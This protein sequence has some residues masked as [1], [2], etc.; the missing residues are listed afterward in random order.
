VQT[1][2]HTSGGA[3]KEVIDR[4]LQEIDDIANHKTFEAELDGLKNRETPL[5][6]KIYQS[7]QANQNDFTREVFTELKNLVALLNQAFGTKKTDTE[8]KLKAFKED[9][10]PHKVKALAIARKFK[11][12]DS[13]PENCV[14]TALEKLKTPQENKLEQARNR[15]K[16]LMKNLKTGGQDAYP[17]VVKDIN[18][19]EDNLTRTAQLFEKLKEISETSQDNDGKLL[20][21]L[22]DLKNESKN[23]PA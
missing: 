21:A 16:D 18:N 20:D 17:V 1:R 10:N 3:W 15:L 5:A 12:Q 22:N 11:H 6:Q 19:S 14:E 2:F 23:T 13:D 4:F 8:T 9:S 7:C